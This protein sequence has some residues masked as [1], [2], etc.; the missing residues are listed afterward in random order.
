MEPNDSDAFIFFFFYLFLPHQDSSCA[1]ATSSCSSSSSSA[2]VEARPYSLGRETCA[3]RLIGTS[4]S[5]CSLALLLLSASAG[6][7]PMP[8]TF[9]LTLLLVAL[10]PPP[11]LIFMSPHK[12]TGNGGCV[13]KCVY[14]MPLS[15][16]KH[17]TTET[18]TVAA[19]VDPLWCWELL[20]ERS[21]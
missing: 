2:A 14:P 16:A 8:S 4:T 17:S 20:Q 9:Q 3:L 5:S 13:V 19:V 1:A 10:P 21:D 7:V 12:N 18:E 15:K 6:R 11:L